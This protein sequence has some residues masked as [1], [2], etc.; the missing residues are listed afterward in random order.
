MEKVFAKRYGNFE[1]ITS[2][3]PS[4]AIRALTGAPLQMFE[5][6][7]MSADTLWQLISNKDPLDDFVI[8][9][10]ENMAEGSQS[11]YP[12]VAPNH[13][14]SVLGTH[15]L[16]KGGDRLV[17]IRNQWGLEGFHGTR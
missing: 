4:E 5:H 13:M 17:K 16:K 8:A 7:D 1:H 3:T 2:G 12:G 15:T 6:K 11:E 10:T 9:G 14:F